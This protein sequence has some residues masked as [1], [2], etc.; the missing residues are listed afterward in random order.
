MLLRL[1]RFYVKSVLGT[2]LTIV[3]RHPPMRT[4]MDYWWDTT[5]QCVSPEMIV[6]AFKDVGFANSGVKE[7]FSGLLRNYTAVKI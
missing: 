7:L 4:L 6:T 2:A 5:E 3:T 1:S